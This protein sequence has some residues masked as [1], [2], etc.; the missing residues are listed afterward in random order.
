MQGCYKNGTKQVGRTAME[1]PR[2]YYRTERADLQLKRK[3]ELLSNVLA[4]IVLINVE[5][6]TQSQEKYRGKMARGIPRDKEIMRACDW[7]HVHA[8]IE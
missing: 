6:L 5:K 3:R 7:L 2:K 1:Y 8:R 4:R